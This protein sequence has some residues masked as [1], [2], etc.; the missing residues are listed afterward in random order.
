MRRTTR[1]VVVI[2]ILGGLLYAGDRE[3]ARL[4]ADQI[5]SAVRSDAHLAQRPKVSVK[6]FPFLT[7][8]VT[9]HYG[10][11]EVVADDVFQLGVTGGAVLRLDFFDLRISASKALSGHVKTAPV[12]RVTGSVAVPFADLQAAAGISGL[13]ITGAVPGQPDE[14]AGTDVVTVGPTSSTV[15]VTG[16]VTF[17]GNSIVVRPIALAMANGSPVPSAVRTQVLAQAVVSV[18]LPGLPPGVEITGVN[19]TSDDVV[20]TLGA[21]NLVLAR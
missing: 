21:S 14:L 7:Q 17:L 20:V 3:A 4:A 19:V 13:S 16:R 18:R 1:L 6:G 2:V 5:A 10:H 8:V 9:G 11:I 15:R 12:K